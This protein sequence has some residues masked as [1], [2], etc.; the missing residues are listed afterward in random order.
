MPIPPDIK[1][2]LTLAY[3]GVAFLASLGL[4]FGI[5]SSLQ[6]QRSI[7]LY[8]ALMSKLNWNANPIDMAR[9]IRTTR[10]LGL[11]LVLLNLAVLIIF[12]ALPAA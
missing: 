2:Y 5:F 7:H 6:P 9:E 4:V 1:F 8:I 11:M 12:F 3:R 10:Q